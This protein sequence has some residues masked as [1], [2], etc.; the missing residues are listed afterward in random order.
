MS[1]HRNDPQW[2]SI[3]E[4][5]PPECV[6]LQI[7]GPSYLVPVSGATHYLLIAYYDEQFRPSHDGNIRWQTLGNN[8]VT[9]EYAQPTHWA[10]PPKFPEL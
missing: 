6:K 4:H 1:I 8:A 5:K 10:Y 3:A 7:C 9:D 2:R